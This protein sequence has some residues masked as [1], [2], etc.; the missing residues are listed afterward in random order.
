MVKVKTEK[1]TITMN[2]ICE[3]LENSNYI[4]IEKDFRYRKRKVDII[5]YDTITKEL[6]FV[7]LRTYYTIDELME[8]E[9]I[10][11]E[12]DFKYVAKRYNRDYGLY[13]IPIRF[14]K[15]KIFLI[16]NIYKIKHFKNIY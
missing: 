15:I 1:E 14:D 9:I 11:K 4:I 12:E 5:A 6:V 8:E 16:N 2:I 13:D 3:Y 10:E 7:D